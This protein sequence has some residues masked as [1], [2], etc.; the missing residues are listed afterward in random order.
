WPQAWQPAS[1]GGDGFEAV[2]FLGEVHRELFDPKLP[3]AGED[4]P[5]PFPYRVDERV[6]VLLD[7]GW[8]TDSGEFSVDTGY[9]RLQVSHRLDAR[10]MQMTGSFETLA[11]AV[12]AAEIDA[13]LAA[14]A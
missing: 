2:F 11:A 1:D 7:S 3:A 4:L 5:L 10:R 14:L 13:H 8:P 12:P 6:E 9:F